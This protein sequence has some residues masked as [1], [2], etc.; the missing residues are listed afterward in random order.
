MS[1]G[2]ER[3]NGLAGEA[4]REEFLRC[5]ASRRWAEAMETRRPFPDSA[6]L[7]RAAEEVA[8]DLGAADW[9]EAFAGHPRIGDRARLRERFGRAGEWS[10]REQA[11]LDSASEEI[12]DAIERGNRSYEERFGH[13]FLVCAAGK[14]AARILGLLR[15]RLRNSPDVE[16]DLAAREQRAITR[17]RLERLLQEG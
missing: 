7:L 17:L 14:D 9:L 15:E 13:V 3:L 10:S 11:G 12:L 6:A 4:A 1:G 2:L 16:L 5:C 8:S